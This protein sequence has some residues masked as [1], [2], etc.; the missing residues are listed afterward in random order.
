MKLFASSLFVA[1]ALFGAVFA[2]PIS[3][4]ELADKAAKG[5]RLLQFTEGADLVWKTEEEKLELM[6]QEVH[7]VG[8]MA[9]NR[10]TCGTDWR[11]DLVRRDGGVRVR[12]DDPAEELTYVF[13]Y[14]TS[15]LPVLTPACHL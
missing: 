5:Y 14:V 6:K 8:W 11:F 15:S 4:E 13:M 10:C 2:A 1:A 3:N 9:G 7:F 12:R